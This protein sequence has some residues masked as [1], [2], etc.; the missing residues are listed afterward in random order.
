MAMMLDEFLAGPARRSMQSG[1]TLIELLIVVAI[2]GIL[3]SIAYPSYQNYVR[4]GY[5]SEAKGILLETA[6]FLERNYTTANRYDLD[7][8]GVATDLPFDT[9]PKSGTA[10]Y[11][12]TVAY[13]DNQ[14]F[15]LSATPVAGG[16]MAGD[17]CGTLSLTHA[18]AQGQS[19]GTQAECWQR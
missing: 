6:Q 13:P 1:V 3:G 8:G 15:T 19:S 18:G 7:S 10:K 9:S 4:Q 11:D 14:S 12:I 16:L 17:A 2:V 5:R